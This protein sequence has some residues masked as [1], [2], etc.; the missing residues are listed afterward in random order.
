MKTKF[1][2]LEIV[3]NNIKKI[4]LFGR[5]Y[6]FKYYECTFFFKKNIFN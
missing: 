1:Y 5:K 3:G 2:K 6:I 4:V